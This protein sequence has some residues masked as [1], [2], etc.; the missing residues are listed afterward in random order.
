S[1]AKALSPLPR[2]CR[3]EPRLE[4]D[5]GMNRY[6]LNPSHRRQQLVAAIIGVELSAALPLDRRAAR[7]RR[8]ALRD[9]EGTAQAIG[10]LAGLAG[11]KGCAGRTDADD[12]QRSGD[13][14]DRQSHGRPPSW[15]HAF[16]SRTLAPRLSQRFLG[17][18]AP[19]YITKRRPPVPRNR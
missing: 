10:A 5:Q 12:Q 11:G 8:S 2:A 18:R 13:D 6:A 15:R 14:L 4:R 1:A 17:I 19:H 3:G 16:P 9:A 7:T